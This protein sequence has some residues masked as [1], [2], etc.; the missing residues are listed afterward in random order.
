MDAGTLDLKTIF[1]Q[2]RRHVVPLYQRPYVWEEKKQWEPLWTDIEAVARR[3]LADQPTRAHFLGAIVLEQQPKQTG[4]LET[5]LV[6]DGQQRLTTLQLLLEAFADFCKTAGAEQ[7]HK[8]LAKLTRNDDPMNEDPVEQFKVWPT[9]VDQE[10]FQAIMDCGSPAELRK[11]YEAKE[12]ASSVD[13]PI[14][15]AYLYFHRRI[16]DWFAEDPTAQ[17]ARLHA[18]LATLREHIRLVVIDLGKEDD[19]QLIFETLNARG[20]PLLPADLV[21]N[22]LFHKAQQAR[23]PIDDLYKAHWKPF[24]RAHRYWRKAVGRGQQ[25][26]ARIDTLLQ[27]YLTIQARDEI[28]VGHLYV[29]FR[30]HATAIN[31]P[32]KTLESIGQYAAMYRTIEDLPPTTRA[33]LF[34][35]R[36][37]AMDT[38]TIMPIVLE[39]FVSS[40]A[41]TAERDAALVDLE[42]FLVRRMI[43]R[44]TPKNYNRLAIDLLK[45]LAEGCGT[46]RERLRGVLLASDADTLR[47]PTDEEFTATL[48][49]DRLYRT[50]TRKRL[51]MFLRALEQ[52]LHTGKTEQLDLEKRLTIEHLM[53]RQ[54]KKHW[55]LSVDTSAEAEDHRDHIVHTLGNLTLLTR[56]LNP[57]VSNGPW[58][59]KLAQISRHS[60]LRLNKEI[61]A[62]DQGTWDEAAIHARGKA[63]AALA[64]KTWPRPQRQPA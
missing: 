54:W 6:I 47:W 39:L 23:L 7:H 12:E 34:V 49:N 24:D 56:K 17:T 26:R 37:T 25:A 38:G 40:G 1:G 45:A 63:L 43:C 3:L 35:E 15:D 22:H 57:S 60:L 18:L 21:K 36:V 50:L 9:T 16:A 51:R 8:A 61:E 27:H 30:D 20:T 48:M 31:S 52:Q 2:D 4:C 62:H 32:A 33:G 64:C 46:P 28:L 42:S 5:R 11:R 59:K 10:A 58:E 41:E 55:P 13:H 44:L 19:A 14:A 53:P 29:A